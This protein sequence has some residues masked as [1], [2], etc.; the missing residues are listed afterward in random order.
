MSLGGDRD[1][2]DSEKYL[3]LLEA[4]SEKQE[5]FVFSVIRM[6]QLFKFD[7]LDL[8]YQFPRNEPVRHLDGTVQFWKSLRNFFTGKTEEKLEKH[9]HK[10]LFSKLVQLLSSYFKK[11]KLLLSLS[12]LPN[13][14]SSCKFS[15]KISLFCY[16]LLHFLILL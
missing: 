11:E 1:V 10:P 5:Q 6:L 8:A 12:V 7:G 9:K 14:N 13:V 16:N 2:C 15:L 4:E 3:K